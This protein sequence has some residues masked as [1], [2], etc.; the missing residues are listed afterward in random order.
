MISYRTRSRAD[1]GE[2][3]AHAVGAGF[4][5]LNPNPAGL[6]PTGLVNPGSELALVVDRTGFE[7]VTH[8]VKACGVTLTPIGPDFRAKT[9]KP[10]RNHRV[11]ILRGHFCDTMS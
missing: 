3:L 4:C 6:K 11:M 10:P 1:S 2:P 8:D 9:E 7:P 5:F